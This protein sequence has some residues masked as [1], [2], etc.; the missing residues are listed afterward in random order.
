M[1]AYRPPPKRWPAGKAG[2]RH[3][4]ALALDLGTLVKRDGTSLRVDRDFHGRIG[5]KTC[6]ADASPY[7]PS[8][9]AAELR[10]IVCEASER[11]LFNVAL[12]PNYN[13]AHRDHFHLEVTAGVKWFLVH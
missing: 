10:D 12:T 9:E 2:S 13:R 11:R 5:A 3:G 8:A 1:S 7:P 6:G 4:G